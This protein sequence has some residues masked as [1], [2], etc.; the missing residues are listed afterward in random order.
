MGCRWVPLCSRGDGDADGWA[1]ASSSYRTAE[2]AALGMC[3]WD[4]VQ[5]GAITRGAHAVAV[6]DG[7]VSVCVY[8]R[9]D[10]DRLVSRNRQACDM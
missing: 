5:E 3:F 6:A 8:E 4:E 10:K 9:M 7:V 2:A 1:G